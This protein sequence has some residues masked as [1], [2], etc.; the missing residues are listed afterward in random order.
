F[1]NLARAMRPGGRLALLAWQALPQNEWLGVMRGAFAMGRELPAP[2]V[3]LPGPFGLADAEQTRQVL[4]DAGFVAVEVEDVRE[5]MWVGPDVDR[6]HAFA[7]TT[8]PAQGMLEYLDDDQRAQAL[9]NLRAALEAAA[10]PDGVELGT[11]AWLY[12]A[13]KP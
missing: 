3:G 13:R 2:P 5:P 12:T 9:D 6:A 11:A 10:G 8:G 7:S 1:A 4:T